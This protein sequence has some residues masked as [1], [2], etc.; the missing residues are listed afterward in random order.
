MRLSLPE[1]LG[2]PHN[3]Q[4]GTSCRRQPLGHALNFV[5]K[6]VTDTFGSHFSGKFVAGRTPFHD[7]P[8]Q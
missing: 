3:S 7:G 1:A 2:L 6:E 5:G 8:R 4:N